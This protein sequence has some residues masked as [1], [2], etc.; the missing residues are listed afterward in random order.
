MVMKKWLVL[1]PTTKRQ[2]ETEMLTWRGPEMARGQNM[3]LLMF[4][5]SKR[6]TPMRVEIRA[7][8]P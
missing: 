5:L 6:P 3:Y 7:E 8:P 4:T 2:R 1:R